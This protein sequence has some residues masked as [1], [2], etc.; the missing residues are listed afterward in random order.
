MSIIDTAREVVQLVQKADN[1]ELYRRMLE[2]QGEALKLFDEN[3][4]LKDEIRELKEQLA[5]RGSLKWEDD[6]YWLETPQGR[7]G[8]FCGTCWDVNRKLVRMVP[9][10][11]SSSFCQFCEMELRRRR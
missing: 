6:K 4:A 10:S 1:I 5:I 3:R 9:G 8:P 7:D 2:L 11:Y